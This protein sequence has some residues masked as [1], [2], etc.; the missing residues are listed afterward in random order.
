G[1]AISTTFA[2]LE[3]TRLAMNAQSIHT[4]SSGSPRRSSMPRSAVPLSGS[5]N[6]GLGTSGFS[7][8]R[9]PSSRASW[10]R[11]IFRV[12]LATFRSLA[13]RLSA[14]PGYPQLGH[15]GRARRN[16]ATDLSLAR[17]SDAFLR[18]RCGARAH[19]RGRGQEAVGRDVRHRFEAEMIE[20]ALRERERRHG[21]ERPPEPEEMLA[22]EQRHHHQHRAELGS[23]ADDLR[24]EEARLDLVNTEEPEQH[25]ERRSERLCEAAQRG[26]DRAQDRGEDR[27]D[28]HDPGDDGQNRP[29]LKVEHPEPDRRQDPVDEA[30]QEPAAH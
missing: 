16:S 3:Y 4:A 22:D 20:Q 1:I 24:V 11:L 18:G 14:A 5:C 13:R 28:A 23:D 17:Q 30:D 21:E 6:W 27:D 9:S 29:V 8:F 19:R 26:W 25:A 2:V 7:L 10:V 12:P 15:S